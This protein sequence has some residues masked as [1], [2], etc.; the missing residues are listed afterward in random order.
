MRQVADNCPE[1]SAK[2]RR[3]DQGQ[4]PSSKA[5]GVKYDR[6][7]LFFGVVNPHAPVAQKIAGQR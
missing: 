5:S 4:K 3:P 1:E 2:R 7:H 6:N